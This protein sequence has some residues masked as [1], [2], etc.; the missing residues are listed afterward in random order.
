MYAFLSSKDHLHQYPV[1]KWYDFTV[2]ISP[3][4]YFQQGS[5]WQCALKGK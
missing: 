4:F 5:G 3:P 1:N 2:E